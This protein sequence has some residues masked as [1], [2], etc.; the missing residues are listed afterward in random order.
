MSDNKNKILEK[1]TFFQKI[2]NVKH[3]EIYIAVIIVLIVC[4]IYFSGVSTTNTAKVETSSTFEYANY[5]EEKL[6]KLLSQ[7]DGAGKVSVMLSLEGTSEIVYATSTEE[8]TN[9]S[10]I[11]NGSTT[12]SV[13]TTEPILS[14][15][16]PVIVKEYLPKITGVIV[17]SQ[18]ANDIKV[19]LEL[20]KAVQTLLDVPTSKIEILIGSK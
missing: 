18:G 2:K 15:G 19:K 6:S 12:N 10:N 7:V 4:A 5:M 14:S 11:T 8:K 20:L 13:V 3:I 16:K 1:V 17:V 9:S